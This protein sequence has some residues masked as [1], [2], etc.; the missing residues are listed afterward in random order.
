MSVLSSL[1][2]CQEA[3]RCEARKWLWQLEMDMARPTH[4]RN[5]QCRYYLR[6]TRGWITRDGYY[7]T[8]CSGSVQRYR[9]RGCGRRLSEQTESIHYF[10]K[11]RLNLRRIFTRVRGGSSLR[12]IARSE[13]CSPDAIG[14]AVLRLARQAMAAQMSLLVGD[15]S[16]TRLVFDGL[17]SC[18]TSGDYPVELQTLVDGSTELL[19]VIT[20]ALTRRRGTRTAAQ[21]R[22]IA[23]KLSLFAPRRGAVRESISLLVGELA[24]FIGT[25]HTIIDTDY[26]PIYRAV[27][28]AD[29]ALAHFA[30]GGLITHRRTRSTAHRGT[31]NPLFPVNLVDRL[32]RHRMKEHTRETIAIARNATM[33][34]HRMWIFA[35]DHNFCQP[36]R[37]ASGS[38]ASRGEHYGVDAS[39]LS[40]IRRSFFT[41][42]I[43]LSGAMVSE[44]IR[45]V[46]S[47]ELESPPVR[48]RVGQSGGGPRIPAYAMADL[49][50]GHLHAS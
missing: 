22:R 25:S 40:A 16:C 24:R 41:T 29:P 13:G 18:C 27:L 34:M 14:Y 21:R 4:C 31:E 19:L 12:D 11:R 1:L 3:W 8:T 23:E 37:V 15:G 30:A 36:H 33:Q 7:H 26:H 2:K 9:C 38:P 28:R 50:R 43:D 39:R 45:R 32:V 46:W 17:I 6:G 42:R 5:R 47:G 35:Y 20:H 48:W 10:A 49:N 44:S